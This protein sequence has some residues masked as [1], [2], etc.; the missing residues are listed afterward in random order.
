[1]GTV[2]VATAIF[3]GEYQVNYSVKENFMRKKKYDKTLILE[4]AYQL[5]IKSG[6]DSLTARGLAQ[7]LDISTQPIY[8]SFKT[9]DALKE[10]L[11]EKLFYEIKENYF[12]NCDTIQQYAWGCYRF[13][14]EKR[15]IYFSF[16]T[17]KEMI[18]SFNQ[19]LYQLFCEIPEVKNSL[20]K[21]NVPVYFAKVTV[22]ISS[23]VFLESEYISEKELYEELIKSIKRDLSNEVGSEVFSSKNQVGTVHH[24]K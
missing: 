14:V 24:R 3:K 2:V 13:S 5:A 4:G 23:L 21:K 1:M 6:F 15:E 18:V 16:L 20:E 7:E 9:M 11:S 8:L 22:L 17:N 19:Y 10:A 12:K